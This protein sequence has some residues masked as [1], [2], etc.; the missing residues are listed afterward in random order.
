MTIVNETIT[1]SSVTESILRLKKDESRI[2][3]IT[4]TLSRE[5]DFTLDSS[6]FPACVITKVH[7]D[8]ARRFNHQNGDLVEVPFHS[9][10]YWTAELEEAVIARI[11]D[12]NASESIVFARCPADCKTIA[13]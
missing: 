6:A 1:K 5:A 2:E 4:I 9:E 13:A 11:G 7:N 12:E 10:D 8:K 3:D